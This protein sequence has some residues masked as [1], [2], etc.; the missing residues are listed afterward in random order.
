MKVGL[1]GGSGLYEMEGFE[2]AGD[3]ALETP[4][5]SPSDSYVHGVLG[6]REVYFLPR[7]GRG[8]RLM[9]SEI[10]H[11]ANIWGFKK[12]GVDVVISVCAVGSLQR[13]YRPRDIH[14]LVMGLWPM[15][16]LGIRC[17]R[18]C[19]RFLRMWRG[20]VRLPWRGM[21]VFMKGGRM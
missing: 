15:P 2:K 10:N 13:Q 17:V 19:V 6:G 16:G 12:L 14:S 3:V 11:R 4:F 18:I 5:G 21:S 1:I 7:H 8:H 20:S 9:P